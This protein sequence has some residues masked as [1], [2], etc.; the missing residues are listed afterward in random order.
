MAEADPEFTVDTDWEE[1]ARLVLTSRE[2]DRLVWHER[3]GDRRPVGRGPAVA[4]LRLVDR[5][6]G[7]RECGQGRQQPDG[8]HPPRAADGSPRSGAGG[9][10]Q[11]HP[12]G[13]GGASMA[14]PLSVRRSSISV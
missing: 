7:E 9:G 2:L 11:H 1:V 13:R 5:R 6:E 8:E 14:V 12:T 4:D 10:Q 3:Q